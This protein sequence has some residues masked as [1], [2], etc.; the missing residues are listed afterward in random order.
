MAKTAKAAVTANNNTAAAS[1][2]GASASAPRQPP[3]RKAPPRQRHTPMRT[4]IICRQVR[5][6]REL[7]RVARTPDG[8]VLLD[9]TGKKSGRGAYLCARR[10]CWEPALRKGKLEREFETTLTPEDR[11]A[12]DAY[13]ASLPAEVKEQQ[14]SQP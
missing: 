1:P 12:L 9:P 11:A 7:I 2:A 8:H 3:K 10:S 4:C 13:V 6:K 14:R 5:P